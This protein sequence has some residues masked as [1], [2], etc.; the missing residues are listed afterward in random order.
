MR[1]LIAG[2]GILL[3]VLVGWAMTQ[4]PLL[5]SFGRVIADPWG[6]VALADLY[7]GF[8]L[9]SVVIALTERSRILAV[10]LIVALF[11]LGNI[12]GALWVAARWPLL[13]DGLRRMTAASAS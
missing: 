2:L 4:A 13:R 8:V 12:V 7:L 5:E 3:A 10:I 11:L 1:A 9:L 6:L